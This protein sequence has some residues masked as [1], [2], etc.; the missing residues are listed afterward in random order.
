MYGN[1]VVKC[2]VYFVE[3]TNTKFVKI[4]HSMDI[5]L[6]VIAMQWAVPSL[7]K[8][9]GYL[10][11]ERKEMVILEG[12]LHQKYDKYRRH[13]EWFAPIKLPRK[14]VK[15]NFV[16]GINQRLQEIYTK[17]YMEESKE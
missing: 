13:G 15:D 16:L 8:M 3:D 1:M 12:V 5:K 11:S 2:G 7:L 10:E 9:H 6:R 17:P 14:I 4:G